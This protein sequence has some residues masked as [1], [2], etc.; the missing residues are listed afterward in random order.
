MKTT[1]D[2]QADDPLAGIEV[3]DESTDDTIEVRISMKSSKTDAL[4]RR[5]VIAGLLS[6]VSAAALAR[7]HVM[8]GGKGHDPGA[9]PVATVTGI[10]LSHEAFIGGSADGTVVGAISVQMAGGLF[11][12]S[13][14]LTGA[15]ASSFAISGTNLVTVGVLAAGNYSINIV[16][17]QADGSGSPFTAAKTIT[18]SASATLVGITLSNSSFLGG[19]ADNTVV[20]AISVQ[21]SGGLFSGSLSLSGTDA[22]RFEISGSNLILNGTQ[23]AGTYSVNI[24]ATQG[25]AVGSPL[26]QAVTIT[27]AAVV[28]ITG[29]SL[30]NSTFI[31][32][33]A[34]NTVVGVISVQATGGLFTG[35]LA[36][37]GADSARFEISGSNLILNGTQA[38][39]TYAINLIATMV[40]ATGSPFNAPK[41]IT[42]SVP[43]A[44]TGI[45][46]SNNSF[47]ENAADGTAVGAISVQTTGGA[48]GGTLSLTGADAASFEIVGPNVVTQ[49]VLAAG[50][51][52]FNIVAT[53]TGATGSPLTQAVTVTGNAVVAGATVT[54]FQVVETAGASSLGY[55]RVGLVFK[56][57][58]V[59]SGARVKLQRG[60]ADVAFQVDNRYY[61]PSGCLQGGTL[62]FRDTDFSASQSRTY[63][64]V[65]ES[66]AFSNTSALSL[67]SAL[68]GT[69]Y[70]VAFTSI[71][72]E[73]SG[74]VSDLTASLN[75]HAATTTRVTHYESGPV[76]DSW[77]VWGMAGSHAHLKT[78]WNF[79]AWKD[80][81]G[82][83]VARELAAVVT[84]DWW[85]IAGKEKLNY[86][87]TLKDGATTIQA[88]SGVEHV[89][90]A[91]W[92]TVRMNDDHQHAR[93]HWRG[94]TRP[95]LIYKPDRTYW[96]ST[97]MVPPIDLSVSY[98]MPA[99][100]NTYT[101]GAE[102][103]HRGGIDGVGAYM[104]RGIMPNTDSIAFVTQT[105]ADVR[106]AIVNAHVGLH[107]PTHYRSNRTRTRPGESADTANTPVSLII[108]DEAGPST[109]T[110]DYDFT[111]E[112]MP[113]YVHGYCDARTETAYTDGF[114]TPPYT[115]G[116]S[117]ISGTTVWGSPNDLAHATAYSYFAYLL[118]GERYMLESG[119][120]D[121]AARAVNSRI[122]SINDGMG[123]DLWW[124]GYGG[125]AIYP[126]ATAQQW[127]G[128]CTRF[129]YNERAVAWALN[130]LAGSVVVPSNHVACNYF[131]ALRTV[132]LKFLARAVG[133]IDPLSV[134][135]WFPGAG[136]SPWMTIWIAQTGYAMY[137]RTKDVNAKT[138]A[139]WV[140]KFAR[141]FAEIN[142]VG[143]SQLYHGVQGLSVSVLWNAVTNPFNS[144]G[145]WFDIRPA[146][147]D[148]ATDRISFNP[149]YDIP[150]Q[151]GDEL[152]FSD[153]EGLADV[154]PEFTLGT[155][156]YVANPSGGTCKVARNP[157]GSSIV[158]IVTSF[159]TGGLG[160]NQ[161]GA[162]SM[163]NQL[164]ISG[165]DDRGKYCQA[166]IE[167]AY[168]NGHPDVTLTHVQRYRDYLALVDSRP[169]ATWNFKVAT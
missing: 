78:V 67:S 125:G 15:D 168:R 165:P 72:G 50:T 19:A 140:T 120:V 157:D 126:G 4:T 51:Y 131:K 103:S 42:G 56:D 2:A 102:L 69:D 29:V 34:D 75:T 147:G 30:S 121:M 90:A 115:P 66:G 152:I 114:V 138:V 16:A 38:A 89:Y 64:V 28:A 134:G 71:V 8:K 98:T 91:Q 84:Q 14:S 59:P 151:T 54:T 10:A 46:L 128:I 82:S 124:N 40:G 33:S 159:S 109:P 129:T 107:I 137:E 13:L 43:F 92:A 116:V 150:L 141:H 7:P 63:A 76:C 25:G 119:V 48:F 161:Q 164:Y 139:E 122:G 35:T 166:A 83:V 146:T 99:Y 101:P 111:A 77:E 20:G 53:Q 31:G 24:V 5:I 27:G 70:K 158:N 97:G 169:W 148:A 130:L 74:S 112:G 108:W 3:T 39:G 106:Y 36:L 9:P 87:A 47:T 6:T 68:S 105:P 153:W 12:G 117:T 142:R 96:I 149:F 154:P 100:I 160:V 163:S 144:D 113:T 17:A 80:A 49:G 52:H 61:Y 156:Y 62:C 133:Q 73:V 45:T 11:S 58:D 110:S 155:R 65:L 94:A 21:T 18:G 86:T 143:M 37:A 41:T 135:A 123:A 55:K 32:G 23:A 104:G 93:R 44:L 127:S 95:T 132:N 1:I 26:T 57:G 136:G 60:G 162:N 118:E 88:Y 22:A 79:T 85:S 81:G 145:A 167:L